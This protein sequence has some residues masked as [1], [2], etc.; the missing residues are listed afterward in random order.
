MSISKIIVCINLIIF[1]SSCTSAKKA[2]I[3]QKKNSTDEF[4]VE[5]KSP[6]VMPPDYDDL[7][8]PNSSQSKVEIED[9]KIKDLITDK[10]IKADNIDDT[11][12]SKTFEE[13]ILKKIKNN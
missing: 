3:N 4:L 8:L 9:A 1:L 6:L 12:S 11:L 5:K 2:F 7:P 10:N 13:N